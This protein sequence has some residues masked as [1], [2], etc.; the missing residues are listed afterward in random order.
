MEKNEIPVSVKGFCQITGL[1]RHS[2]YAL[3][4]KGELD[5]IAHRFGPRLLRFYPS[6]VL[7]WMKTR[8]QSFRPM[9]DVLAERK[10]AK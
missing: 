9:K 4:Y 10:L 1:S 8:Q 5:T 7:A 2:V 3:K 6:E